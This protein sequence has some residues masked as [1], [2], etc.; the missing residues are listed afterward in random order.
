MT[1]ELAVLP[2]L[3]PEAGLQNYLAE[4]KKFPLLE[5]DEEY[6]LAKRWAEHG[7]YEAAHRLITSHLRLVVK[8]A[9]GYKGYGLPHTELIAEGNIGLMQA[10]KKFDPDLGYRLSTYAMWWIKASI[11]E[12]VL[13]S[14]SLV[15]MGTSA[16]HKKLFFNLRKMKR[17]IDA[18]E[19]NLT[20]EQTAYIAQ[21]LGV[22]ERDVTDMNDRMGA[23]DHFLNQTI[24]DDEDS[25]E[26]MDLLESPDP[27][28]E[29]M[30]VEREEMKHQRLLLADAMDALNERERD[31]I[32]ERRLREHPTTLEDLS[33]KYKIS[34]ERVRQIETRA[35]EK[36]TVIVLERSRAL[37]A[38]PPKVLAL[39]RA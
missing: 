7:D 14:W 12:F 6:M 25:G 13:R 39:P 34:R 33:A 26:Y 18:L 27:N 17:Q 38:A 5:P 24:G 2:A 9:T 23:H 35:M 20:P 4:I 8:I 30:L 3:A 28:Q 16:S 37:L 11:Q 31:I 1:H 29:D 10:I 19:H 32:Q 36:L 22:S 21:E 15:K